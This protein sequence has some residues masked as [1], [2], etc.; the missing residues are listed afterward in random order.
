M[1][2]IA[3]ALAVL[4]C[5]CGGSIID[6]ALEGLPAAYSI[7]PGFTHA[8]AETIRDAFDAWCDRVG[9]C[10]GEAP[11]VGADASGAIALLDDYPS[12]RP[13]DEIAMNDHTR[14]R[15]RASRTDVLDDL[16]ALWHVTAHEIGHYRIHG[17]TRV[18]LMAKQLPGCPAVALDKI[19]VRAWAGLED[20]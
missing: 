10:P 12:D 4:A 2:P 9:Y 19:A 6:P 14:I 5:A 16:G 3:T 11:W 7:D 18:G 15:F 17:H 20:F 1:K 8:Q 13:E